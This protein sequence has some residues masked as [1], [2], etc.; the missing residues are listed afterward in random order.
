MFGILRNQIS[1]HKEIS[2]E[3]WIWVKLVWGHH[4]QGGSTKIDILHYIQ[5][6][7]L[8]SFSFPVQQN[9]ENQRLIIQIIIWCL[10]LVSFLRYNEK[11]NKNRFTI[12]VFRS[13]CHENKQDLV[14]FVKYI[15]VITMKF[16]YFKQ[17][18]GRKLDQVTLAS[19]KLSKCNIASTGDIKISILQV[20]WTVDP[21]LKLNIG[22]DRVNQILTE[23]PVCL[24]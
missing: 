15:V 16:K 21:F 7:S 18:G 13:L 6:T 9:F 14:Y 1:T 5:V 24:F 17:S 23:P 11:R 19:E 8:I 2:T 12:K 3:T 20:C 22:R 10:K 4:L